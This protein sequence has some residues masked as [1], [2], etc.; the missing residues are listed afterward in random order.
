MNRPVL[1][2]LAAAALVAGFTPA[3][4]ASEQPRAASQPAVQAVQPDTLP[5]VAW[6]TSGASYLGEPHDINSLAGLVTAGKDRRLIPYT[7]AVEVAEW[8]LPDPIENGRVRAPLVI[9][10][11]PEAEHHDKGWFLCDDP[12]DGLAS[13]AANFN[14]SAFDDIADQAH[15]IEATSSGLTYSCGT[16]TSQADANLSIG[17]RLDE[18]TYTRHALLFATDLEPRLEVVAADGQSVESVTEGQE[19]SV[20]ISGYAPN[21]VVHVTTN[22]PDGL[23]HSSRT[24]GQGGSA[25]TTLTAPTSGSES[26]TLTVTVRGIDFYGDEDISRSVELAQRLG[27]DGPDDDPEDDKEQGDRDDEQDD[28]SEESGEDSPTAEDDHNGSLSTWVLDHFGANG[29]FTCA[30]EVM[31][32]GRTIACHDDL[33]LVDEGGDTLQ[34]LTP[35]AQ[36]VANLT[37]ATAVT[38]TAVLLFSEPTMLTHHTSV[39]AQEVVVTSELP[40]WEELAAEAHTFVVAIA[41]GN[42]VAVHY[43]RYE[44]AG[45][46]GA[47]SKT[48]EDGD[49][50]GGVSTRLAE[51]GLGS[52]ALIA[53]AASL[54]I[55]GLLARAL[56][57]QGAEKQEP[58]S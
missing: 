21:T 14:S 19:L 37:A 34:T 57:R 27:G 22:A 23:A 36:V 16:C 12:E 46:T 11:G 42:E 3:V 32:D 6:P 9:G 8:A 53:L 4:T 18:G 30:E 29:D 17:I 39:D 50:E 58:V 40:E 5:R 2:L 20:R 10:A 1:T 33:A 13:C 56:V 52:A 35:G 54:A 48:N 31:E 28:P 25:S 51:T 24:T 15:T 44:G 45:E 38:E 55:G 26:G 47:D 49:D 41:S 43:T 7:A